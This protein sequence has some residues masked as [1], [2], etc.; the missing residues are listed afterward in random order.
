[1]GIRVTPPSSVPAQFLDLD[2]GL[3]TLPRQSC[4][5]SVPLLSGVVLLTYFRAA[6]SLTAST[7]STQTR[8]TAAAG[9]TL[10]RVGLYEA[11]PA[12]G[13][14]TLLAATANDTS[15]WTTTFARSTRT[16]SAPVDLRQGGFYGAAVLAIGTTMPQLYGP[17]SAPWDGD[18]PVLAG[19]KP[20]Q[21]DLPAT[22]TGRGSTS[23]QFLVGMFP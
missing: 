15:M 3:T 21:T 19:A 8:G 23:G 2:N 18:V 17:G 14:G 4:I 7:V 13:E 11:D 20:G 10:A 16:L 6:R 5:G 12:T 9:L 1:M 22:L